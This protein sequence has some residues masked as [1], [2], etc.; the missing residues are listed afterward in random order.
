MEIV[1]LPVSLREGRGSA[2]SRRLRRSGQLP[3]IL[4]G[5]KR[6][7]IALTVDGHV[8]E[9]A[10]ERGQRVFDL[11]LDGSEKRRI[12]LLKDVQHNPVGDRVLHVDFLRVDEEAT[13]DVSVALNFEG[14]PQ[15]VSGATLEVIR[16]EIEVRCKPRAIPEKIDVVL[17]HLQVGQTIS[18]GEVPLP[19]DVELATETD[20]VLVTFNV[21]HG[22]AETESEEGEGE[23]EGDGET[24]EA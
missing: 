3:G 22:K 7:P 14:Q 4:Y 18:A 24:P 9:L 19:E 15:A 11:S 10:F 12:A 23:D 1:K 16:A 2:E 21:H 13:T 20:T 8:F 5:L 17:S 6:D